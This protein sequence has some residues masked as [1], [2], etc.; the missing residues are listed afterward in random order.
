MRKTFLNPSL[1]SLSLITNHSTPTGPETFA[2]GR[3]GLRR[4]QS[5][6]LFALTAGRRWTF[7]T[8]LG[9]VS[10]RRLLTTHTNLTFFSRRERMKKH[11]GWQGDARSFNRA[12]YATSPGHE[13]GKSWGPSRHCVYLKRSAQTP[14]RCGGAWAIDHAGGDGQDTRQWNVRLSVPQVS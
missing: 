11:D 14:F 3:E 13:V 8:G 1:S 5:N 4:L 7:A 2:G 12:T 6:R 10:G 9:T